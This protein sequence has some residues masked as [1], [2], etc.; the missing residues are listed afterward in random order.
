MLISMF[1]VTV[2]FVRDARG[3]LKAKT[4]CVVVTL[5]RSHEEALQRAR[6]RF[7]DVE[8]AGVAVE[9]SSPAQLP[10]TF[11]VESLAH[12]KTPEELNRKIAEALVHP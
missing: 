12:K 8:A 3:P 5:A 2:C 10:D 7:V 11:T 9:Y 4:K 6:A 1:T